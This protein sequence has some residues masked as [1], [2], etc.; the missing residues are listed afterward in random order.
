VPD[1]ASRPETLGFSPESGSFILK[2]EGQRHLIGYDQKTMN[3]RLIV[4]QSGERVENRS[5]WKTLF[6]F[7]IFTG[8]KWSDT[9]TV[10][11]SHKQ[12]R[13]NFLSE[14]QIEGIEEITT[15]AGTYKAFKIFCDQ[16]KVSP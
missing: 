14:F 4:E 11:T 13:S 6:D 9:S 8:K 12:N 5:P 7:P 16:S 3:H 1:H 15:P 2:V 10:I